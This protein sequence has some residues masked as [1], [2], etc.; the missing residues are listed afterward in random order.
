MRQLKSLALSVLLL[1]ALISF[2]KDRKWREAKFIESGSSES[3]TVVVPMP[4]T[5]TGTVTSSG[6]S[7]YGTATTTGGMTFAVPVQNTYY[8]FRG[9]SVIYVAY[10]NPLLQWKRPS[11]TLGSMVKIAAEGNKLYFINDDG[12]QAHLPLAGQRLIENGK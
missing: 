4:S 5:T 1:G 6:T 8:V 12:K 3:G 11:L 10:F 9:E 7:A 2:A